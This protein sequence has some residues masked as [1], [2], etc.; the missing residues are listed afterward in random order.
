MGIVGINKPD[1]LM[2]EQILLQ[3]FVQE[4]ILYIQLM[5]GPIHGED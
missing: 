5:K 4:S 2:Y 3:V 1:R